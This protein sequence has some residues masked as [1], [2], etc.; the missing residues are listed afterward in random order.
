MDL[1]QFVTGSI[2]AFTILELQLEA[3]MTFQP[4]KWQHAEIYDILE[5]A[6]GIGSNGTFVCTEQENGSLEQICEFGSRVDAETFSTIVSWDRRLEDI[7][8]YLLG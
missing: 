1:Q 7:S 5:T 4:P 6:I 8:M 2:A 3:Y